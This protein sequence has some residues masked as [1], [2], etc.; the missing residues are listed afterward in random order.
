M[1]FG[2]G[3]FELRPAERLRL[4][5]FEPLC[6]SQDDNSFFF[7]LRMHH[8]FALRFHT[9]IAGNHLRARLW[10]CAERSGKST[11]HAYAKRAGRLLRFVNGREAGCHLPGTPSRH[12]REPPGISKTQGVAKV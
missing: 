10:E 4:R 9:L 5:S 7:A 2:A 11:P 12:T 3:S 1:I 6:A 8:F